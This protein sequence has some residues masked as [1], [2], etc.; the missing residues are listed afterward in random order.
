M[1]NTVKSGLF[2]LAIFKWD[3]GIGLDEAGHGLG[4]EGLVLRNY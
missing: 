2:A 1:K 4:K 3:A